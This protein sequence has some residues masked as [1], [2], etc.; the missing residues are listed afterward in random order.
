MARSVLLAVDAV[1][2]ELGVGQQPLEHVE[3]AKRI[4]VD[5]LPFL[6]LVIEVA[7]ASPCS[8]SVPGFDLARSQAEPPACYRPSPELSDP[9]PRQQATTTFRTQ[10]PAGLHGTASPSVPPGG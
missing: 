9:D 2:D 4:S 5:N 3:D 8:A 10:G 6:D 7:V 1:G